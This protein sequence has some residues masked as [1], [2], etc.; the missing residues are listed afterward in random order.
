MKSHLMMKRAEQAAAERAALASLQAVADSPSSSASARVAAARAILEHL[1]PAPAKP[2]ASKPG[3][4]APARSPEEL[5]AA[6]SVVR[7]K[8]YPTG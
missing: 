8:Q 7:S 4:K 5:Q 3:P 1:H 6:L 2:A